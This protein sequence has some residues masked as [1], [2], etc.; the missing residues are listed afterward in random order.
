MKL[1]QRALCRDRREFVDAHAAL[2]ARLPF[3]KDRAA[4]NA[5]RGGT[6]Q[7]AGCF[8]HRNSRQRHFLLIAATIELMQRRQNGWGFGTGNPIV[9]RLR[10]TA[11]LHQPVASQ[12]GEMLRKGGLAKTDLRPDHR[13]IVRLP[14]MCTGSSGGVHFPGSSKALKPLSLEA[15]TLSSPSRIPKSLGIPEG[16]L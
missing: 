12:T 7:S 15:A 8:G 14:A 9:D 2:T 10:G 1:D 5:S 13:P 6:F 3:R 16:K 11:G 4:G